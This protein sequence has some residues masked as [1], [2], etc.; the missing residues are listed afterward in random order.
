MSSDNPFGA[1]NQ[2]ERPDIAQWVVGFVDGEG[3]FS[4]PIFR[5]KTCK[6]GWQVQPEFS[7][8]QGVKSVDVLHLLKLFFQCGYVGR[9]GRHDNHRED[10]YR[11]NVRLIADLSD[12]I[13][14]FFNVASTPASAEASK[15]PTYPTQPIP[16]SNIKL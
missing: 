13:I 10:L 14:P 8:V 12:R 4:V 5:N 6:L 1:D 15:A 16:K 9:N 2:Q 3:C 7:V 11:F